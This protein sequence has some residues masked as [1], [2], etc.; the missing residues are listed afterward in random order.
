ADLADYAAVVLVNVNARDLST[1]VMEAIQAY[2]RDLG[3]GLVVIGGPDS[4]G[5]GGY[6]GTP[7]EEARPVAMQIDDPQRFPAVSLALVIDRSGSMAATEGGIPKIQLAAEGAV[8][9]LELLNDFDEMTLI[10]VDEAPDGVIGPITAANRDEAI[11]R[12]RQLG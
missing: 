10:P 12:M 7:L 3:G 4:Y 8:R 11:A 6:V 2:V 9:A 5:V 1:R